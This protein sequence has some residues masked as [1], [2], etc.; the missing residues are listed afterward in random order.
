MSMVKGRLKKN[1][2]LG[3]PFKPNHKNGDM[4][5]KTRSGKIEMFFN[6]LTYFIWLVS[7]LT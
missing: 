3:S 1:T 6:L 2:S 4:F 7:H 5:E